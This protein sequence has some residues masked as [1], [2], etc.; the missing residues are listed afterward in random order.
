ML[1][2]MDVGLVDLVDRVDRRL[3]PHVEADS[4]GD[5]GQV[6]VHVNKMAIVSQAQ[7]TK[8]NCYVYQPL[9]CLILRGAKEIAVG[10]TIAK[11]GSGDL[12]VGSH[13]LPLV[14]RV[15]EASTSAPYTALV[16]PIDV[17]VLRSLHDQLGRRDR[18][19]TAAMK[20]APAEPEIVD[21]LGR[22]VALAD[23]P[24]DSR[25]LEPLLWTELHYR[26]LKAASGAMLNQLLSIDSHASRIAD[27][28]ALIR[29]SIEKPLV[30]ADVA[31]AVGMSASSFHVH[32]KTVTGTS[33]LQYQKDLRLVQARHLLAAGDMNAGEVAHEVGYRSASQFSRE[34]RRKFGVS[35]SGQFGVDLVEI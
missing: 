26:L 14:A 30:V 1:V 20:V 12:L 22:Y 2:R 35:P 24:M 3:E 16:V 34:Y 5:G 31:A 10:E 32:F 25:V 33:P 13:E 9:A 29:A 17:A 19:E 27:A 15:A 23:N 7:P 8:A 18:D 28:I 6:R 11:A 21:C 4:A